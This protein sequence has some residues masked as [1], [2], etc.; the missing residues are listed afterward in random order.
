MNYGKFA[1]PLTELTK[2]DGFV[3][4]SGAQ[5][6]FEKLKVAV[7]SAPMLALPNFAIP[8]EIECDA[9]GKGIG[10]GIVTTEKVYCFLQ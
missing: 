2:K 4:N 7:T 9:C 6:A 10:V 3:W 1:K 8:F 5:E